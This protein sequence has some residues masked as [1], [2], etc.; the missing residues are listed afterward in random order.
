VLDSVSP[1]GVVYLWL[2]NAPGAFRS[3]ALVLRPPPLS[4][5]ALTLR[6]LSIGDVTD[7]GVSD[8]IG[9]WSALPSPKGALVL[10][11]GSR[12]ADAWSGEG[13]ELRSLPPGAPN[14]RASAVDRVLL[15]DAT[16]DGVLD[17]VCHDMFASLRSVSGSQG[18]TLLWD[19]AHDGTLVAARLANPTAG[20][21]DGSGSSV[22]AV[23]LTGD[24]RVELIVLQPNAEFPQ[25]P[26]SM[27][28]PPLPNGSVLVFAP[29]YPGLRT[30]DIVRPHA[31]T[32]P[33]PP[34]LVL[35]FPFLR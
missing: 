8:V 11:E 10:W 4:N 5:P 21:G 31:R 17:V 33:I 20:E 2:G 22:S 30:A 29:P 12:E 28:M 34:R 3:E 25:A 15:A 13:R 16:G 9:H 35:P 7:D 1:G 27:S 26:P 19:V 24:G 14:G 32:E 6:T 23:D 18:T